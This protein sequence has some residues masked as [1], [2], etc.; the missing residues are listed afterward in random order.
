M[1]EEATED[2]EKVIKRYPERPWWVLLLIVVVP[3]LVSNYFTYQAAVVEARLKATEAKRTAE[4]GYEEIVKAVETLKK[5]DDETGKALASINGHVSALEAW[6][7]SMR[8]HF[9]IGAS[10][11]THLALPVPPNA[12]DKANWR[13]N[14]P[15]P[16][17]APKGVFINLPR[18]L[19]EAA[20]K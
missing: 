9:E 16:T 13:P 4:A 19:D 8:P 12:A 14:F 20:K 6:M 2:P 17:A 10:H 3:Q 7:G 11:V 5:H 1:G 15:P 18:S